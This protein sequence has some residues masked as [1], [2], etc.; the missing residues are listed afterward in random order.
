[1]A[2]RTSRTAAAPQ[3]DDNTSTGDSSSEPL[4][5]KGDLGQRLCAFVAAAM[6]LGTMSICP[7]CFRVLVLWAINDTTA[8]GFVLLKFPE[9]LETALRTIVLLS[10]PETSVP[11]LRVRL[12]FNVFQCSGKETLHRMRTTSR[13]KDPFDALLEA[14]YCLVTYAL[15]GGPKPMY[16]VGKDLAR[17][18][19]FFGRKGMWPRELRDLFPL[20]I[21][22]TLDAFVFWCCVPFAELPFELLNCYLVIAR[23]VIIEPFLESPRRDR[24]A[25]AT[26]QALTPGFNVP[27]P[28]DRAAPFTTPPGLR[29]GDGLRG[30]ERLVDFAL[31]TLGMVWASLDARRD[32]VKR[33][34]A[35]LEREFRHAFQNF[36]PEVQGVLEVHQCVVGEFRCILGGHGTQCVYGAPDRPLYV[37]GCILRSLRTYRCAGPGCSRHELGGLEDDEEAHELFRRCGKCKIMRYCNVTCQRAHWKL[38]VPPHREVCRVFCEMISGGVDMLSED[39]T[40]FVK[41]YDELTPEEAE[42]LFAAAAGSPVALDHRHLVE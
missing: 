21:E 27:W 15:K 37:H 7:I 3:G 10:E 1:M 20:G 35:G 13:N 41:A 39:A 2:P 14:L 6:D 19:H 32:D 38:N 33:F 12:Q 36:S 25:W 9:V 28:A 29:M 11:A 40:A 42:L 23:P 22:R 16:V 4:F 31:T 34:L 17:G 5:T 24:C 30:S 8:L 18:K 26:L